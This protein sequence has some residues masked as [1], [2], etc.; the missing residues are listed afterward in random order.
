MKKKSKESKEVVILAKS[1]V[2]VI[3]RCQCNGYHLMLRNIQFHFK[4]EEF[5]ALAD[6]FKLARKKEIDDAL[7]TSYMKKVL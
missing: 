6:L 2:G 5:V 4:Q 7:F 3:E 1:E